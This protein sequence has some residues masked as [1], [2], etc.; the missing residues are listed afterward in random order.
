MRQAQISKPSKAKAVRQPR[1]YPL[2]LRLI[3][4]GVNGVNKFLKRAFDQFHLF[5]PGPFDQLAPVRGAI[6]P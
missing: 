6:S 5:Y 3:A 2:E 4:G 1:R